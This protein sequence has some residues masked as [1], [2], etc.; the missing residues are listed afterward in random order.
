MA[1]PQNSATGIRVLSLVWYKILPPV[2][3][4]QKG[5]ALFNEYLGRLTPL[6]CLCSKNN[7]QVDAS[8]NI[9]NSLPIAKGQFLN[10]LTW[11]KVYT[12]VRNINAT[13]LILEFPYYGVAALLCK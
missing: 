6:T 9:D 2:F 13:H 7:E 3:G 8:Y 11:R 1:Q 5:V 4:G 10:P 12:T